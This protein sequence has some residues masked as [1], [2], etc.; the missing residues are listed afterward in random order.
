MKI[1]VCMAFL[2][3]GA[4]AGCVGTRPEPP[5]APAGP[6]AERPALSEAVDEAA[7]PDEPAEEDLA[8]TNEPAFR[9]EGFKRVACSNISNVLLRAAHY[10]STNE[11]IYRVALGP[12]PA[13]H[14]FVRVGDFI[15]EYE[16]VGGS[17]PRGDEHLV[18]R[19]DDEEY[20]VSR[21]RKVYASPSTVRRERKRE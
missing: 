8:A 4:L 2:L 20:I 12:P 1:A 7:L 19:K 21:S 9:Y 16:V 15:G 3:A 10:F 13:P 5:A 6:A 18:L 17:G 11:V 14:S